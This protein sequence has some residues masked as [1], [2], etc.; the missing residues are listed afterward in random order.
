VSTLFKGNISIC[1]ADRVPIS[2]PELQNKDELSEESDIEEVIFKFNRSDPNTRISLQDN[3]FFYV[4]FESKGACEEAAHFGLL[5]PNGKF[6]SKEGV[7]S[8]REYLKSQT[9]IHVLVDRN[10][11][12]HVLLTT[13][14]WSR[15]FSLT[16]VIGETSGQ[17]GIVMKGVH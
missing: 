13:T 3:A 4:G 15:L 1:L 5:S 14:H 16:K 17:R 6:R 12:I 11:L 8:F 10:P 7:N 9:V 2:Q